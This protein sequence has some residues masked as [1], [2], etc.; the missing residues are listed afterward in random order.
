MEN[1]ET[2]EKLDQILDRLEPEVSWSDSLML[3]GLAGFICVIGHF[4]NL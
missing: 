1:K 3:L 2:N 4:F